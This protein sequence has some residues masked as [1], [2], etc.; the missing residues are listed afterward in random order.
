MIATVAPSSALQPWSW[1]S[2]E[3]FILRGWRSLPG[4]KPVLH[5]MHGTGLCAMAY[6]PLLAPLQE[7]VDLFL[8]DVHGHGDSD[9]HAPFVGWNRS[10]ELAAMAWQA[11][12]GAYGQVPVIAGGHSLGALLSALM[13]ADHPALFARGLLLDPVVMPPL[14]RAVGWLGERSGLYARNTLAR[15]ARLRLAQWPSRQAASDYFQGRGVFADWHPDA[16]DAYIDHGLAH[17]AGG[18]CALKCPPDIEADIFGSLPQ[19]LWRALER[20]RQPTDVVMGNATYP[21]ALRAAARW[22]RRNP[23]VRLHRV[24]GSHCWMQADPAAGTALLRA[25]LAR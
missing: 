18:A 17:T 2:P 5:F 19:G 23:A 14:M 9:G 4:G 20:L 22:E 24:P 10:A 11:H 6:W 21:F 15:R 7:Q 25:L 1:Q 8:S 16:L 12:A 13:L 3:G